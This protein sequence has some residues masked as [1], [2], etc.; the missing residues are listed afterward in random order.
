MTTPPPPQ[1]DIVEKMIPCR[2][3]VTVYVSDPGFVCLSQP[4]PFCD[5]AVI[6]LHP[7]LIPNVIALLQEALVEAKQDPPIEVED[8]AAEK[9]AEWE[10]EQAKK[11]AAAE[12]AAAREKAAAEEAAKS[13]PKKKGAN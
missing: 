3:G 10:A 1:E 8:V 4:Q 7:D 6:A 13:P 2:T 12:A 9:R 11:K 5:D